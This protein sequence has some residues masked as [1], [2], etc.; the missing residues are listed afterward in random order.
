MTH[1]RDIMRWGVRNGRLAL[2]KI[3]SHSKVFSCPVNSL[4]TMLEVAHLAF[5]L[6]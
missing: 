3:L 4:I 5:I 2:F 6:H 1:F